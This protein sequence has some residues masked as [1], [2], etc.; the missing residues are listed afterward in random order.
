[1]SLS[2]SLTARSWRKVVAVVPKLTLEVAVAGCS[3]RAGAAVLL[4]RAPVPA[5]IPALVPAG[6]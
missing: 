6:A 4:G 3:C 2:L 1:M 5:V